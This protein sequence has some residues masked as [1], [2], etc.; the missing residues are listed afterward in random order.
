MESIG[1]KLKTS[2]E[3]LGYSIEQIARE[4][5]IAKNY[6]NALEAEDFETF[7]GETYL[8]GFLRNYSEYLGI[9]PEEMINLYRN[10]MIQEQPAPME[11]LLDTK[12]S[13]PAGLIIAIV[14]VLGLAAAGYFYI[15]PNF[16]A[17]DR[18]VREVAAEE[19]VKQ[20]D[21][22]RKLDIKNVYEFS[23]EV[24]EKRFRVGEAVAVELDGQS[25]TIAVA[26]VGEQA[27]LICPEGEI[28]VNPGSETLVD[29]DG[30]G[31]ADVRLLLRSIDSESDSIILHMDRFVQAAG[32][33]SGAEAGSAEDVL[34]AADFSEASFGEAGA[35]E[36][37]VEP[38]VIR[39]AARAE[40]FSLNIVFRGYCLLRY[41]SDNSVREERY[42]HKGETFRLNA[43]SEVRLWVS[44]AGAL[45]GKVNGV[46]I[47]LGRPGEISTRSIKW[48]YNETGSQYEL[49][50]IPMY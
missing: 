17:K 38:V 49:Q 34:S 26:E 3:A 48:I 44:N 15:Y 31:F 30:N 25:Y 10:M 4:T 36:R 43:D 37:V 22:G 50:L 46:D 8:L 13:V 11:E 5:N 27:H 14:A 6:L 39:T 24:I 18:P 47:D 7:P 23:D 12:K 9:D 33:V 29:L 21:S 45:S 41:F 19:P 28:A 35:E 1:L 42:F 20:E 16:I 2:R 40:S 32:T